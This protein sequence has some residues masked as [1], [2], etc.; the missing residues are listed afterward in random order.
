MPS[1]VLALG[2]LEHIYNKQN[3]KLRTNGSISFSSAQ[4]HDIPL[5][6]GPQDLEALVS[7]GTWVAGGNRLQI[8]FHIFFDDIVV[9]ESN[10]P[11]VIEHLGFALCNTGVLVCCTVTR[12]VTDH[13]AGLVTAQLA[14]VSQP[15]WNR[16]R[17]KW[18]SK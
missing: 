10:T 8:C 3:L 2:E 18:I 11:D 17:S 5:I 14:S 9:S 15:S 13:S 7:S 1:M 4:A 12:W 6:G 16:Q